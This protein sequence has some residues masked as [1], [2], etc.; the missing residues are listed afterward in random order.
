[1][2]KPPEG[3]SQPCQ[4]EQTSYIGAR[5]L[6]IASQATSSHQVSYS[7]YEFCLDQA[8][9]QGGRMFIERV[10]GGNGEL[11]LNIK[12]FTARTVCTLPNV[13][14]TI[15]T[16]ELLGSDSIQFV[17]SPW[18]QYG[19]HYEGYGCKVLLN[20]G[21]AL[22]PNQTLTKSSIA[23]Y[24]VSDTNF[25]TDSHNQRHHVVNANQA[26]ISCH[27]DVGTRYDLGQIVVSYD[28]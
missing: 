17:E 11:A 20:Q 13:G 15:K 18:A 8:E 1:M 25:Y 19:D 3:N 2:V 23:Y 21:Q 22:N 10:I 28:Y 16:I 24:G 26:N 4:Q 7:P 6:S 9:W 27:W 5:M 14:R 12:H